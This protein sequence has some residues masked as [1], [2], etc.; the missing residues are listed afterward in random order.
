MDKKK[1]KFRVDINIRTCDA[2]GDRK[3]YNY[4][5]TY[6]G[7]PAKLDV[8][9]IIDGWFIE[10]NIDKSIM[11]GFSAYVDKEMPEDMLIG[12]CY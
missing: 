1:S 2:T 3:S 12:G 9:V 8:A 5:T 6:E 4:N 11:S 10:N 7:D